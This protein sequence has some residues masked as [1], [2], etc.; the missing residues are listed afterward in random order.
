MVDK[1]LL[2]VVGV[3]TV[4][5]CHLRGGWLN[6]HVSSPL[7]QLCFAVR[8]AAGGAPSAG[9]GREVAAKHGLPSGIGHACDGN[10]PATCY[11]NQ[12]FFLTSCSSQF[13]LGM[14]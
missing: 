1:P 9:A 11:T 4:G 14:A 13:G 2:L 12:A 10:L 8:I 6:P 7:R 3:L 5:G